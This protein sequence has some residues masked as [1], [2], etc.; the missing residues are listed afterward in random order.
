[1]RL[2]WTAGTQQMVESENIPY[3]KSPS[4]RQFSFDDY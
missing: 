1:M 4:N 2:T 3:C